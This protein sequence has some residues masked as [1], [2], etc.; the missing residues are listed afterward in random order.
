[1]ETTFIGVEVRKYAHL[2]VWGNGCTSPSTTT[3]HIFRAP[4]KRGLWLAHTSP[5]WLGIGW[6][7]ATGKTRKEVVR[8][9]RRQIACEG[10]SEGP[11]KKLGVAQPE[12]KEISGEWFPGTDVEIG[13]RAGRNLPGASKAAAILAT[14]PGWHISK[15]RR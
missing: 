6:W 5:G 13:S 3:I 14:I 1:M 8:E 10:R 7:V 2:S 11:W 15:G 12:F 9:I 4:G